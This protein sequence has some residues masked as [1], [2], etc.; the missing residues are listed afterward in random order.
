VFRPIVP[1]LIELERFLGAHGIT[2]EQLVDLAILMG[3]D[4]NEGISGIGPKKALKLV[5]QYGDIE[6]MPD[7]VRNT[8]KDFA[9]VREIYLN[10]PITDQYELG[11]KEPDTGAI[12]DFL[13]REREFSRDRV[14]A[15]LDRAF[16][17][18]T[19]W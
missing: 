17:H 7:D 8:V 10:P 3:T 18:P 14:A 12:L 13:C 2:R 11:F 4:F 1:E 6:Q 15:A 9:A 16:G 5:K 19:L